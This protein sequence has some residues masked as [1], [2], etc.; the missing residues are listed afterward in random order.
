[1]SIAALLQAAEYIERRERE[2]EHGYASTLPIPDDMRTITKRPKT[3]KS[4]GSRTT[5]NELE[6]NRRA[7]LRTC[8]EKLK[9]LVPLGPETSRHTTLGLLTKAKR[10]IKNLEDRER[11]HAIHKEQLSREHRFLRR[12]LEQLT[13]QTGLHGLHVLHG[14]HGLNPSAPTGSTAAASAALLSK[15]RSIS[16]CSL[17]T[18]SVSSTGSSRNSD[19]SAGSPSVSE[20]DEV[21]VIGYTSNQSDTDDH[22]SVQSSSD[23]G[24]AMSTSRLTLS[25]MMDNL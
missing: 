25:E 2:A 6:K 22:S 18:A 17:G 11:K 4:Q 20:S 12:R 16:E 13:S 21:D 10:F 8:L 15:R 24:V 14:L 23:S 7:H 9:L 3:K 19:R 1:M 5:H